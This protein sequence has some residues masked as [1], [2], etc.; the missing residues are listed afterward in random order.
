VA[1]Y[2]AKLWYDTKTGW[3]YHFYHEDTEKLSDIRTFPGW[4]PEFAIPALKALLCDH[5]ATSP[6][7]RIE[8]IDAEPEAP[9]RVF[10]QAA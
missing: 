2:E 3:H 8:R 7:A 9:I 4:V 6:H 5:V 1:I 10:G